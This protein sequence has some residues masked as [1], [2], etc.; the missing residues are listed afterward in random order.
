MPELWVGII[1]EERVMGSAA[2]ASWLRLV[3]AVIGSGAAFIKCNHQPGCALFQGAQFIASQQCSMG[4][5]PGPS[6]ISTALIP[7]A[8]PA[9][10]SPIYILPRKR[11]GPAREISL[12]PGCRHSGLQNKR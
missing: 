7:G 9:L 10:R 8:G 3:P 4:V 5:Q 12:N 11:P 1:F 2:A 6:H